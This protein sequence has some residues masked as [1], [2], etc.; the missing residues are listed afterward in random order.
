MSEDAEDR[1]RNLEERLE[2][3]EKAIRPKLI[4]PDCGCLLTLHE[5]YENIVYEGKS[6]AQ[7]YHCGFAQNVREPISNLEEWHW[8]R[9]QKEI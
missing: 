1:L 5:E 6:H 7:C 4:C 8:R 9:G 3:I 2:V